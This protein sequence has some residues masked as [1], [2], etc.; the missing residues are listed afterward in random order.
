[1]LFFWF[2]RPCGLVSRCLG[3][4]RCLH[5]QGWIHLPESISVQV[6]TASQSRRQIWHLHS[7]ENL[8]FYSINNSHLEER[9]KSHEEE[10]IASYDSLITSFSSKPRCINVTFCPIPWWR[11]RD[12][13]NWHSSVC[14]CKSSTPCRCHKINACLVAYGNVARRL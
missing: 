7:R 12:S 5:L 9:T 4:T 8:V 2:V 11:H 3:G 6:H 14:R 1:M 13:L 10:P